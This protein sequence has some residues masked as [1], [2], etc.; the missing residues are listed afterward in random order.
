MLYN[1][2]L[3]ISCL[4]PF[5]NNNQFQFLINNQPNK[6]KSLN[7]TNEAIIKENN[8]TKYLSDVVG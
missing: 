2:S 6:R 1:F 5:V 8:T 4:N 3:H 7:S